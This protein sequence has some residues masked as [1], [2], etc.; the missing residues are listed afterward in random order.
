MRSRRD[1]SWF[2]H[3]MC[4]I[5]LCTCSLFSYSALSQPECRAPQ[6]PHFPS[7][8]TASFESMEL[9]HSHMQVFISRTE[10]YLECLAP[11]E[12]KL[13][14]DEVLAKMKQASADYN[15]L[16]AAY[17]KQQAQQLYSNGQP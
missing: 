10:D 3:V 4:F 2:R 9:A 14:M 15:A 8:D 17:R 13:K 16:R 12:R 7:V 1:N 11:E 5:M 6:A